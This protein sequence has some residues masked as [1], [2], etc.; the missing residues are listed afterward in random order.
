MQ[1]ALAYE[2]S[3]AGPMTTGPEPTMQIDEMSVRLGNGRDLLDPAVDERIRVVRSRPG[4]GV[5]LDR[6]RAQLRQ[7]QPLDRLVVERDVRHLRVLLRA[8]RE[9]VVLA[10][11]EH[12]AARPLEHR[13]VDAA[14]AERELERL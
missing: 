11:D 5:E 3:P 14:M 12:P 10:R 1:R 6:A 9:A 4:L 13:M 8:D 7:R 2:S